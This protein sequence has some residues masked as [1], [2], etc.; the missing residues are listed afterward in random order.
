M[1]APNTR[2]TFEES[3]RQAHAALRAGQAATAEAWLRSLEAQAP[4]DLN[5]QWLLG[6]A[7]LAQDKIA[8]SIA[9]LERVLAGAP[10][11][12]HARVDLARASRCAG[13]PDQAP[14]EVRRAAT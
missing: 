6:A 1:N 2:A 9:I 5:C 11:F 7:L 12:A 4:G 13:S 10:G 14:E 8:E 3:R